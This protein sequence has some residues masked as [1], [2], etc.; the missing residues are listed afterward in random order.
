MTSLRV[1][2]CDNCGTRFNI[3]MEPMVVRCLGCRCLV[4][5]DDGKPYGCHPEDIDDP[6]YGQAPA[7]DAE[8][9]KEDQR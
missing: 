5:S 8:G 6:G 3:P 7:L 4:H 2:T 1:F 9:A